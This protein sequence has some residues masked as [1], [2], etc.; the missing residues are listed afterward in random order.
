MPPTTLKLS[1]E[2]KQRI[3][4][5]AASSGTSAHAFMIEALER[6]TTRV[7]QRRS[8]VDEALAAREELVRTGV[9]FDA[10]EV[11]VH[12]KARAAGRATPR[13]KARRWHK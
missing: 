10:R 4:A 11:H 13:P 6:E 12:L 2:L 7:E 9:G 1:T 5:V 8:F 3:R